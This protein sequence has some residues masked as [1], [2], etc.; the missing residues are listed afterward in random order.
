MIEFFVGCRACFTPH[1]PDL[2]L[3]RSVYATVF[4]HQG[5]R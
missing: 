2:I 3:E 5:E 4:S 1:F